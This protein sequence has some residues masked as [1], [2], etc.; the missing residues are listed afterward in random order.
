MQGLLMSSL[1][2]FWI[3]LPQPKNTQITYLEQ[4]CFAQPAFYRINISWCKVGSIEHIPY[5]EIVQLF[6]GIQTLGTKQAFR[7][8]EQLH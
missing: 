6:T 3:M 8:C 2:F 7:P 5:V 4:P 1:E